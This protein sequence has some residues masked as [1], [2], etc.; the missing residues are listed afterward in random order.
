M[1]ET[2]GSHY[3][4]EA[5]ATI[6]PPLLPDGGLCILCEG[7]AALSITTG[8]GRQIL[9]IMLPGD[10]CSHIF[11][12]RAFS[13]LSISALTPV[14]FFSVKARD[15]DDL[16][17][18]RPDLGT[19][20]EDGAWDEGKAFATLLSVVGLGSG[21]ERVAYLVLSILSRLGELPVRKTSYPF[22]LRRQDIAAVVGMSE[23]HVSR[24][25]AEYRDGGIMHL[26][27]RTLYVDNP[28]ALE[29]IGHVSKSL[30]K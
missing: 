13:G 15:L 22:P 17:T 10:L 26:D 5:G 29:C 1:D 14:S 4:M 9:R 16:L 28:V 23:V 3:E 25:M 24:V 20:L 27:H 30:A 11:R 12:K 2:D 7:W 19:T 21:R 18:R 6:S 8:F